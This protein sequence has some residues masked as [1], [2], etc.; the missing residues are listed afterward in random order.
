MHGLRF[1]HFIKISN[2]NYSIMEWEKK[3]GLADF[4]SIFLI[5]FLNNS[6][7]VN[8]EVFF[9]FL[10]QLFRINWFSVFN[11][12]FSL[13]NPRQIIFKNIFGVA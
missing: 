5:H 4:F 2:W 9:G 1:R 7:Y 3:K 8:A 13:F 10:I 12:D 6:T 11:Q